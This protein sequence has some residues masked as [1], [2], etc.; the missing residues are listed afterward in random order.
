MS[1]VTESL[2]LKRIERTRKNL[3]KN[4]ITTHFA[5][6]SEELV[7]IIKTLTSEGSTVA[8]GGSMSL[9]ETDVL[10][11]LRSGRYTFYDRYQ[12]GLTPEDIRAIYL[13]SF[14]VDAYFASSN[15]VTEAGELYNVDGNGNRVAAM[16]YGPKKVILIV[17]VNKI[18]KD[19]EEAVARNRYTAAPANAMR[20]DTDTPCKSTGKCE[21]CFSPARICC[22]YTVH[23]F[24]R[25]LNRMHLIFMNE[26]LG[27]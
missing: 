5:K 18:V 9:F 6:D 12:E 1:Q 21:D 3:E 16:T 20:L 2:G 8:V 23:G 25:T 11:H 19:I 10:N 15:A 26:T 14:D 27:Y 4:N 22:T 17:G 7:E 13:K 24:Q